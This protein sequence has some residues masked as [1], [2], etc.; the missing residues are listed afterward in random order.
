[1]YINLVAKNLL[2]ALLLV[3]STHEMAHAFDKTEE[4]QFGA[5]V[6]FWIDENIGPSVKLA[7][8]NIE[9]AIYNEKRIPS[10]NDQKIVLEALESLEESKSFESAQLF[11]A[12][13]SHKAV[14]IVLNNESMQLASASSPI[15]TIDIYNRPS[16]T[17]LVNND[18]VKA[19]VSRILG[20]ELSHV[21]LRT[22]DI[23]YNDYNIVDVENAKKV[24]A[25]GFMDR[26]LNPVTGIVRGDHSNIID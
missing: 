13:K 22:E 9:L 1:M 19:S 12:L 8:F 3:L 5:K 24:S 7:G 4:D 11:A 26:L 23:S 20:H 16:F 25:V 6:K 21:A 10:L 2:L 17:N 15:I 18:V 14:K